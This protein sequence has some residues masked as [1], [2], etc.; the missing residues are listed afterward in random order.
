MRVTQIVIERTV[1]TAPYE[2]RK[3]QLTAVVDEGEN[4]MEAGIQLGKDVELLATGKVAPKKEEVAPDL[5]KQE[6]EKKIEVP[7]KNKGGR[8][9]GTNNNSNSVKLDLEGTNNGPSNEEI[10]N[11]STEESTKEASE[12]S[13]K[14]A[15]KKE[16]VAPKSAVAFSFNK[17]KG[18]TAHLQLLQKAIKNRYPK[19]SQLIT[20]PTKRN[21]LMTLTNEMVGKPF[22]KEEG[23]ENVLDSFI[24]PFYDLVSSWGA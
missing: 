8:P 20:D 4:Y 7:P 2:S 6:E 14:E 12:E 11:E 5:T 9:R 13:S 16:K 21:Q 19:A 23:S 15:S 3:V 10:K 22:I 24:K 17:D 1:Q 18:D